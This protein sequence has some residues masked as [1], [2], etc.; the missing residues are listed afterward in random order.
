[1]LKTEIKGR[2]GPNKITIEIAARVGGFLVEKNRGVKDGTKY[3][4]KDR[5]RHQSAIPI[6]K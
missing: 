2:H 6:I 5:R 3:S 1:M 4:R